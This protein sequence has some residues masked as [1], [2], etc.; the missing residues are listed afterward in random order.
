MHQSI[1]ML[2]IAIYGTRHA[3]R[4]AMSN[5]HNL[6]DADT[7]DKDSVL[8]VFLVVTAAADARRRLA[9]A[10][11]MLL[12]AGADDAEIESEKDEKG[13]KSGVE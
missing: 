11:E 13:G 8:D 1:S 3:A 10:I 4:L 6:P 7:N 5:D 9:A 2:V 12:R